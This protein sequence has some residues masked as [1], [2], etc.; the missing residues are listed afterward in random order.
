MILEKTI[1]DKPPWIIEEEDRRNS[2]I[3]KKRKDDEQFQKIG[4]SRL[5]REKAELK[6]IYEEKGTLPF[7][8]NLIY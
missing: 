7:F 4:T 1:I 3:Q 8:F 6:R 5:Q 2:E